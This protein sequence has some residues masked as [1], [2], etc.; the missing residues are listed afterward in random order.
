LFCVIH[1]TF[2]LYEDAPVI[3]VRVINKTL[4]EGDTAIFNCQVTGTPIPK[5][6]WYFNDVP[7]KEANS[8][9]Y[10]IS[11]M[12]FNPT[13]KNNTLRVIDVNSFDVGKYTCNATNIASS[14]TSSGM[15]DV[16]GEFVSQLLKCYACMQS[17]CSIVQ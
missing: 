17:S 7:V 6:S 3:D 2:Y 15:L 14:D 16:N 4:E 1:I 5:I 12:S 10:I 9:K 13:T 11:E 8:S